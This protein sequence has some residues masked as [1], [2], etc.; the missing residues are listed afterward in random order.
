MGKSQV[1]KTSRSRTRKIPK[2]IGFPLQ[3]TSIPSDLDGNE[4]VR[5]AK[6]G[7]HIVK[8]NALT[9]VGSL[10]ASINQDE[11]N[12]MNHLF[13]YS[14][15]KKHVRATN[16][17][18]SGRCWMFAALNIFRHILSTGLQ[19][20]HFEFSEVYLFFWDKWERSNSFLQW[21]IDHP[22]AKPN[23]RD[24]E[25][26]MKEDG[27][28]F[29]D[30]GYWHTFATLV[31]K[32]GL[33]PKECMDESAQSFDSHEMNRVI[34]HHLKAAVRMIELH[35]DDMDGNALNSFKHATLSNIYEILVQYLGTPPGRDSEFVWT[36]QK[37]DDT[38]QQITQLTPILF[39]QLAVPKWQ[40]MDWVTITHFPFLKLDTLYL[41]EDVHSV[42][43][44]GPL[45][46]LNLDM[47]HLTTYTRA[48]LESGFSTW[49]A[50]DVRQHFNPFDASL[51]D[52]IVNDAPLFPKVME[53][54][55]A[56]RLR[57]KITEANHAMTVTGFNVDEAS[58]TV[59][60]WQIE[61]SWGYVNE[62]IPGL[63]GWLY[64]SAKWF[65]D[66]VFMVAILKQLMSKAHKKLI[67][68]STPIHLKPYEIGGAAIRVN[69]IRPSAQWL[70]KRKI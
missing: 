19:I 11:L 52:K 68:D 44:G 17:G 54:S 9:A 55:K 8:R 13:M 35:R 37:L 3:S 65:E 32:Y 60:S 70:K 27:G 18:S 39:A 7:S 33:V 62:D 36:M 42:Q 45:V 66:H 63:D 26:M 23:D 1:N 41:V 30:G 29:S 64:A 53:I 31:H 28:Y 67:T 46:F 49:F 5:L 43:E 57:L 21:F 58:D 25:W 12:K 47:D 48:S 38:V 51:D 50:G 24:Y 34:L 59:T 61:N 14:L 69:P 15:K 4:R 20:A 40:I 22:L 56:D 2:M 16:Q 6:D 10:I